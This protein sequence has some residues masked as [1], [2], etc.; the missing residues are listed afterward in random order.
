MVVGNMGSAQRLDYTIMGDA[1]NLTARLEGANKAYGSRTM[2]SESTYDACSDAVDVRELD[3]IMVVGKTEPVTVY[4]LLDRKNQS[5]ST[6]A[7]LAAQFGK[8]LNL[9]RS[10]N[11]GLAK[12]EF[13]NCL[14]IVA[15][16]G[17]AQTYIQRCQSY[18]DNPPANDWDGV[19]T[20]TEKGH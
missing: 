9:Y 7:D 11:F 8:G 6:V 18:I 4:E 20:L 3:R 10:G 13:E 1:V 5:S 19:F 14:K 17:P 15:T 16:D 12:V 2:I